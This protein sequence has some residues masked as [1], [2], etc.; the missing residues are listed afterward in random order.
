MEETGFDLTFTGYL[1]ITENIDTTKHLYKLLQKNDEINERRPKKIKL[2]DFLENHSYDAIVAE[3][4]FAVFV[5]WFKEPVHKD[6][7]VELL[8]N[9]YPSDFKEYIRDELDRDTT[10]RSRTRGTTTIS[11]TRGPT[12]RSHTRGSTTRSRTRGTAQPVTQASVENSGLKKDDVEECYKYVF[13]FFKDGASI[14]KKTD[15]DGE[16]VGFFFTKDFKA[17]FKKKVKNVSFSSNVSSSSNSS[18]VTN[19]TREEFVESSAPGDISYNFKTDIRRMQQ[20]TDDKK[21]EWQKE[22]E[23]DRTNSVITQESDMFFFAY[24]LHAPIKQDSSDERYA[25]VE[26]FKSKKKNY[27]LYM[28]LEY[29]STGIGELERILEF[30]TRYTN[31]SSFRMVPNLHFD[32]GR[33]TGFKPKFI[34]YMYNM[35]CLAVDKDYKFKTYN[36]TDQRKMKIF[37]TTRKYSN[38]N[39]GYDTNDPLDLGNGSEFCF[40]NGARFFNNVKQYEE[41]KDGRWTR[42]LFTSNKKM[43]DEDNKNKL[44]LMLQKGIFNSVSGDA[45]RKIYGNVDTFFFGR[46]DTTSIDYILRDVSKTIY[47]IVLRPSETDMGG[48]ENDM[49]DILNNFFTKHKT[50]KLIKRRFRRIAK[51]LAV[52]QKEKCE[53]FLDLVISVEGLKNANIQDEGDDYGYFT[54]AFNLTINRLKDIYKRILTIDGMYV[55]RGMVFIGVVGA[56]IV[57]WYV[58]DLETIKKYFYRCLVWIVDSLDALASKV[59]SEGRS[60]RHSILKHSLRGKNT[61]AELLNYGVE[62]LKER[63]KN[64]KAFFEKILKNALIPFLATQPTLQHIHTETITQRVKR[65]HLRGKYKATYNILRVPPSSSLTDT[66][67]T[68]PLQSPTTLQQFVAYAKDFTNLENLRQLIPSLTPTELEEVD[69]SDSGGSDVDDSQSDPDE[70][71]SDEDTSDEDNMQ[72]DSTETIK[73][74]HGGEDDGGD[75]IV[76]VNYYGDKNIEEVLHTTVW[77]S[78][79]PNAIKPYLTPSNSIYATKLPQSRIMLQNLKF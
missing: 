12:T 40:G 47:D 71:T 1:K 35:A 50:S 75:K 17:E 21:E 18:R 57:F 25:T 67:P 60:H 41:F 32:T 45:D 54:N 42:S 30:E 23:I 22:M 53:I 55:K 26:F 33:I 43:I 65:G 68:Q 69:Y 11:S 6:D 19:S 46:R 59:V 79:L 24:S 16:I 31:P 64:K 49:I 61:N 14:Q 37:K 15:E 5:S 27:V 28:P 36:I 2:V 73:H 52:L 48:L 70:D 74:H 72:T 29:S 7:G 76:V 63:L 51:T 39:H 34:E 62:G 4:P 77:T 44:A 56:G 10:T 13:D 9:T 78:P 8:F 38:P 66:R 3:I 58:F 20:I